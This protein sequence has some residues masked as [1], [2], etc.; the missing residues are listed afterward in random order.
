MED[1]PRACAWY[2]PA[3]STWTSTKRAT[4][5]SMAMSRMK[6]TTRTRRRNVALDQPVREREVGSRVTLVGCRC[7]RARGAVLTGVGVGRRVGVA[8]MWRTAGRAFGGVAAD[9]AEPFRRGGPAFRADEPDRDGAVG[10]GD[11]VGDP[12]KPDFP[13]TR[14]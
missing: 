5:R 2:D 1:S 11:R 3:W 6:R 8:R 9:R 10:R 4:N 12:A 7:G 14:R 13:V